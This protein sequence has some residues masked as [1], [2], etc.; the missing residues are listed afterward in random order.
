[1]QEIFR[2]LGK[3]YTD[4]TQQ[5]VEANRINQFAKLKELGVN[6][7]VMPREQQVKWAH[8]VPNI[9]GDWV[10]RQEAEGQPARQVLIAFMEGQRKR[11]DKPLRDWDK[12]L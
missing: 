12:E 10:K 1:L 5:K 7:P 9:A 6:F 11:G 2:R 8:T 4:I 3:D